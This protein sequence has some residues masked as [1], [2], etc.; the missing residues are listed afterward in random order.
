[1]DANVKTPQEFAGGTTRKNSHQS[2]SGT[3]SSKSN[4]SISTHTIQSTAGTVTLNG[5]VTFVGPD[6]VVVMGGGDKPHIGAVAIGEPRP[7]LDNPINSSSSASVYCRVGH[8]ED[9]LA[10][11]AALRLAKRWNCAVTVTVGI[12]FN[13]VKS[14][15]FQDTEAAFQ[16]LLEALEAL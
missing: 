8:K 5:V 12:H 10:R 7:S 15:D 4:I 6:A 11:E 14:T 3:G 13:D 2:Y 1:M 9:L 16:K